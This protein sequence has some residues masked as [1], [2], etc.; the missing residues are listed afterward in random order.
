MVLAELE[1]S[2]GY[3]SAPVES[4]SKGQTALWI[5]RGSQ[6]TWLQVQEKTPAAT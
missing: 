2:G 1:S 5:F 6:T 4:N 3:R